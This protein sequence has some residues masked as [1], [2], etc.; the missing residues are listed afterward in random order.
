MAGELP[1]LTKRLEVEEVAKKADVNPIRMKTVFHSFNK[2]RG[3]FLAKLMLKASQVPGIKHSPKREIRFQ[4]R[5]AS[6][7]K[8]RRAMKFPNSMRAR[9]PMPKAK[10]RLTRCPLFLRKT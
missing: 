8:Y 7:P 3:S 5:L 4:E 6:D 9:E 10:K 1:G 2:F